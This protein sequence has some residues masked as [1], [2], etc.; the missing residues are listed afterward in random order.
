MTPKSSREYRKS[1]TRWRIRLDAGFFVAG[2]SSY[3]VLAI[4]RM[5]LW[6]K[7]FQRT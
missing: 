2:S 4:S 5:P 7:P 6:M 1:I 3:P